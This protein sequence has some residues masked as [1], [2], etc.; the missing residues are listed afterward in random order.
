MK[1]FIT[2]RD[3]RAKLL[4]YPTVAVAIIAAGVFGV[5][6]PEQEP[7]VIKPRVVP[8]WVK[9]DPESNKLLARVTQIDE[10]TIY[11][12]ARDLKNAEET[13]RLV[14][15]FCGPEENRFGA[16]EGWPASV[17]IFSEPTPE[18]VERLPHYSSIER[19]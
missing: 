18:C 9:K 11:I 3:N 1:S 13:A 15:E 6:L 4:Y 16:S 8:T 5:A 19:Q 7:T 10:R 2:N 12:D 14:I 17:I